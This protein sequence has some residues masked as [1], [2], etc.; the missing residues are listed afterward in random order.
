MGMKAGD[1]KVSGNVGIA[2][3]V[4]DYSFKGTNGKVEGQ[5]LSTLFFVTDDGE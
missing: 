2:T 5:V 3:F 1:L 4:L